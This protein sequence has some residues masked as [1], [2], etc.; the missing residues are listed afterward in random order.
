VKGNLLILDDDRSFGERAGA[1]AQEFGYDVHAAAT[2]SDALV[3]TELKRFDCA[4]ID[5]GLPDGCGLELLSNARLA[6]TSKIVMSGDSALAAWAGRSLPGALGVLTKPFRFA[7]FRRLL[8]TREQ[9]TASPT[10]RMLGESAAMRALVNELKAVAKTAFPVLI[11][12]ESG[13]GKE[14]AARMIHGYSGRPGRLVT[15]NCAALS[16]ELL[17]S[18]MF[19][20]RRGSFT[21]AVDTHPGFIEQ[22]EGG[23]LFLDEITEA[24]AGVQ[25]ALLRFLESG[26]VTPLGS[27]EAKQADVR[28]LAATNIDPAVATRTGKLRLDLYYRIAGYEVRIPPLR[29]RREDIETIAHSILGSLNAEH[30]TEQRFGKSAF[31]AFHEYAWGGNVRELRQIVQREWLH[32]A[33]ELILRRADRPGPPQT[34][35][36]TLDDIERDAILQALRESG[37]DRTAAAR[38]L[39]ISTKTVYNK[40]ERYRS[41]S[42]PAIDTQ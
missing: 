24:P 33:Q 30:G 11:H 29:E 3:A 9:M 6:D 23:T 7:A 13:T 42:L 26:E 39:G 4:L 10:H 41:M 5:I 1:F 37:G 27:R 28:V 14:L 32:G 25:A 31:D 15:V 2:L 20:H 19:G 38:Q 40:L 12:G 35:S 17:G 34:P 8:A 22:A 16:A 36:R 18:Q 21:G